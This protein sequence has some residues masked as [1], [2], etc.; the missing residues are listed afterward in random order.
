MINI[1]QLQQNQYFY[2]FIQGYLS[3]AQRDLFGFARGERITPVPG[4]LQDQT[5]GESFFATCTLLCWSSRIINQTRKGMQQVPASE[6]GV[7]RAL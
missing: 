5:L 1:F 2:T 7:K 6:A 3:E 4:R